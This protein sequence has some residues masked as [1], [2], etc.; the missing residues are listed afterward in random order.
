MALDRRR[1]LAALG[2]G[3]SLT[4]WPGGV[5]AE[6]PATPRRQLV[7]LLLRGGLDGLHALPAHGDPAWT[8]LRGAFE[9]E[10]SADMRLDGLFALH[11]SLRFLR[12]LHGRAELLPVLGV[13]P[14]YQGRSHFDAQDCLENGGAAPGAQRDGWL[15]RCAGALAGGEP[16]AIASVTPLILRGPAP[17]ASWWPGL[18]REVSPGLLRRLAPLYAQAPELAAAYEQASLA[19]E[20]GME[21]TGMPGSGQGRLP[22]LMAKAGSLMA[23]PGGPR[24]AFVEDGGWDSHGNQANQLARKLSELDAAIKALHDA[25][26]AA[27]RNTVL[28]VATEFG[29]TAAINGT[30]GTD[31]GTGSHALLAGGAV[32]GGRIAGAWPG[33][34]PG[35]LNEGRD[36]RAGIDMRALFKGVLA[37]HLGM[38]EAVLAE[39]VFPGS[40]GLSPMEGLVAARAG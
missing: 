17:V 34:A 20:G 25:L 38:D 32:R 6:A 35:D 24:L 5:F 26:G 31:H 4:L 14:P 18:P 12:G 27:W 15:N 33:L 9:L 37:A 3:A 1:F 40:A 7:V 29:R 28:V 16:L 19:A 11:P 39:T 23:A 8:R 10:L 22:L 36:L 30:R 21:A 13:A 2:A